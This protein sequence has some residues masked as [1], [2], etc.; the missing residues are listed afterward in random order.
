MHEDNR[1]LKLILQSSRSFASHSL[2]RT[3]SEL[4]VARKSAWRGRRGES[5]TAMDKSSSSFLGNDARSF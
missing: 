5:F 1:P 2:K 3:F 4:L